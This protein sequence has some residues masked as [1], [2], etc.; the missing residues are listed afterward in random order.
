VS[1]PL[2]HKLKNRYRTSLVRTIENGFEPLDAQSISKEAFF[3][4]DGITRIAH[5]GAIYP[6][7]RD[8]SPLFEALRNLKDDST[9][10]KLELVFAGKYS[11]Y[12]A[13]LA[14]RYGVESHVKQLGMLSHSDSLRMQRDADI[15][16][17]LE[18]ESKDVSGI[19]SGKIFEYMNSGTEI[20]AIGITD[21]SI[22]G[23]MLNQEGGVPP[24]VQDT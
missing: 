17:F 23:N 16:L 1:E 18:F 19:I 13:D 22:V 24:V 12:I 15:L 21:E 5:T 10:L 7:Y 14:E 11:D 8:P 6:G 20:W 3:K 4:G 9:E 2:N